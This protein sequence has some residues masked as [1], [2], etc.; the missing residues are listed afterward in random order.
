MDAPFINSEPIRFL[1]ATR[2]V[3]GKNG[4]VPWFDEEIT[5]RVGEHDVPTIIKRRSVEGRP[6]IK[7]VPMVRQFEDPAG[8]GFYQVVGAATVQAAMAKAEE[9]E[10]TRQRRGRSYRKADPDIVDH[11]HSVPPTTSTTMES[12]DA[13]RFFA[14]VALGIGFKQFGASWVRSRY[15]E[16][17]RLVCRQDEDWGIEPIRGELLNLPEIIRA[18]DLPRLSPFRTTEWE[19]EVAFVPYADGVYFHIFVFGFIGARFRINDPN[20]FMGP[21][22]P[23]GFAVD[24][25][26]RGA[27]RNLDPVLPFPPT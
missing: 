11:V 5:V 26:N 10:R 17:L 20:T 8:R 24:Y 16:A 9:I 1:C 19:H 13:G 7:C 21:A 12:N 27:I 4:K 23:A 18:G 15:A 14:K 2:G 22:G 6:E 25:R 3:R